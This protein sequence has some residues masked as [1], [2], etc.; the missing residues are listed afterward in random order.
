MARPDYEHRPPP[1]DEIECRHCAGEDRRFRHA[2]QHRFRVGCGRRPRRRARRT[3]PPWRRVVAHVRPSHPAAS[4]WMAN[5][6]LESR[7]RGLVWTDTAKDTAL[8][9]H[10]AATW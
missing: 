5:A 8:F 3:G 1:P 6:N 2:S 4:T 7:S 10:L 9:E